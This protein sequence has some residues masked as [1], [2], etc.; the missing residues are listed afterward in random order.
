MCGVNATERISD[1]CVL[2]TCCFVLSFW[3]AGMMAYR[4][5]RFGA[6]AGLIASAMLG[7]ARADESAAVAASVLAPTVSFQLREIGGGFGYEWGKGTLS[8][9]GKT[10]D[11]HVGGG[12]IGSLGYLNI[13]GVGEVTNLSRLSDFDGTYW[14]ASVD[15]AAGPGVGEA[16][17]E[18]QFGVHLHLHLVTNGAHLGA[19]VKRLRFRL[20]PRPADIAPDSL[21]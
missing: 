13:K 20:V 7:N 6:A 10:Y 15:A 8:F 19:S 14:T 9:N 3:G 1:S 17:L 12:G 11:F 21:R 16:I 5:V 4:I 18:N 2:P